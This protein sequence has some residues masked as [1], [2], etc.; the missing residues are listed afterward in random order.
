VD[1][2]VKSFTDSDAMFERFTESA[3][4]VIMIAQEEARRLGWNYVGTEMLLLGLIGER[5]GLGARALQKQGLSTE[6]VRREVE[7]IIGRG[8]QPVKI[9]MPFTARAK[10]CLMHSWNVSDSSTIRVIGTEHVLLGLLLEAAESTQE[11]T[12]VLRIAF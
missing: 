3:I 5:I 6:V 1:N 7:K 8:I 4:K 9:E 2:G 12:Q 10:K 11:E